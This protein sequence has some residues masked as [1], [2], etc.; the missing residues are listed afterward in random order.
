[1]LVSLVVAIVL[2]GVKVT[3]A[4]ITESAAIYSDAAESVVHALAVAFAYWA[5]HFSY[6]PADESHHFGHDKASFLSAG[7]EGAMISAAALFI[8]YEAGRQW[9]YGVELKALA[10]GAWL[11]GAAAGVN[12]LLG[13]ALVVLGKRHRSPL[14]RAN[15]QHVLT[16]VWTSVAVLLALALV[17]FTG[18]KRWDPIIAALAAL[19]ILRTGFS[20]IRESLDGLLDAADPQ[21]EAKMR[22]LLDAQKDK[23]GVTYHNLRHRYS[24]RRHWV[25]VHLVF[26]ESHSL[27]EAHDTATEIEKE[28]A[29]LLG[30]SARII[31]HLEPQSAEHRVERWEKR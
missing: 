12:L 14:L 6:K 7:F 27:S 8:L 16:D 31:S 3:A 1:M 9:L 25:E 18:W 17:Y 30:A 15:G 26:P 22:S 10:F 24:G 28:I 11:T 20:L 2:L 21:A 23:R 29:D 19:N 5:L 4:V 13:S